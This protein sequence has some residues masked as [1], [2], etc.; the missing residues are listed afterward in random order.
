MATLKSNWS[1]PGSSLK[2]LAVPYLEETM[3]ES[4]RTG[5]E[6]DGRSSQPKI[7]PACEGESQP[8]IS[9]RTGKRR[10]QVLT[11]KTNPRRDRVS[12]EAF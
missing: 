2:G 4:L 5:T 12:A 7:T 11:E 3:K 8:S 10:A 1:K 9:Q 6:C